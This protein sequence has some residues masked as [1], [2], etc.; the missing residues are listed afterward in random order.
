MTY[1]LERRLPAE[2]E[3]QEAIMITWP[4]TAT[5]WNDTIEDVTQCYIKLANEIAKRESLWIVTPDPETVKSLIH[6]DNIRIFHCQTNDTWTRDHGFISV[7]ENGVRHLL[8]FRF[9]AWG[10][11]F[12]ADLDNLINQNIKENISGI[13]ENHLDIELEGGSI[14]SDGQGTILTTVRCNRNANR[15]QAGENIEMELK[16]RLGAKRVIWIE[17]GGLEHDDTDG[18]I[19]TLARF[20]PNDTIVYGEG[21]KELLL[22]LKSLRTLN[23]KPYQLV[24]LPPYHVNFLIMNNA[25]LV[26]FYESD[27]DNK[28]ACQTLRSVF[29]QR[30]IVGIDCKILL[31][32]NGSLHCCTMQFPLTPQTTER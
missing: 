15:R 17:H 18:H 8:D 29:P 19:D 3:P 11:K 24:P 10:G 7:I 4:H 30:D 14:E 25:V 23:G 13:Y 22:E 28:R 21:D 27:S 1:N 31:T 2:W 32:Q 5:D 20:A 16:Q 12:K 9:N 6:G 26:P